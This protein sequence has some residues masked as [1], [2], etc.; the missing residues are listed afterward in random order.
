MYYTSFIS[1]SQYD[2]QFFI[3]LLYLSVYVILF[4]TLFW[5]YAIISSYI[6]Y[7]GGIFTIYP[8]ISLE[9]ERL[10]KQIKSLQAQ[11]ETFPDGDFFSNK[12]GNRYKWFHIK[13][14]KKKYLTKNHQSLAEQLAIKKYL[15]LQLDDCIHEKMQLIFIYDIMFLQKQNSY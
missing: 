2:F 9:S 1:L 10:D 12:N 11:L 3:L 5:N 6:F 4:L 14:G 15:S 8:L 13:N 7:K